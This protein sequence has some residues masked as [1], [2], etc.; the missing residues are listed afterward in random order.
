MKETLIDPKTNKYKE[1]AKKDIKTL[2][3]H[4][5]CKDLREK[6]K[7]FMDDWFELAINNIYPGMKYNYWKILDESY[8]PSYDLIK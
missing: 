4:D 5:Y 1:D 3:E 2:F 6:H 8:D 7:K